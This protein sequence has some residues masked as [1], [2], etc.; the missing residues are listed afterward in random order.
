MQLA[1]AVQDAMLRRP[2]TTPAEATVAELRRF[3][4]DD[5]VH[6]AL[7]VEDGERLVA[8]LER[9]DLAGAAWWTRARDVGALAGRIVRPDA[10]LATVRASMHAGRRRLAV[11]DADGRLLGLLCLKRH[12]RGFCSDAEVAARPGTPRAPGPRDAAVV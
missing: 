5:H 8:V 3:F 7:L 1:G 12:G 2:R 4:A 10:D 11:V 6:A 9:D